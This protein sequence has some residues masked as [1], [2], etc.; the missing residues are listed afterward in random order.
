MSKIAV[1]GMVGNSA[2]L[3]VEQFHTG[4]ETITAKGVHF[5]PS[6]KGYNQAVA[7]ARS[8]AEVSFLGAVGD[9]GFRQIRDFSKQENINAVLVQKQGSTAYAAIVTD[10]CGEN[11][12]T[13]YQG[14]ALRLEDVDLF[15]GII[16]AADVLLLNNEVPEAVNV[17]AVE[18]A[19][20]AGVKVILNPAPARPL[21]RYLL[22][23]VSLFTPNQHEAEA[24]EGVE[25]LI[26]TLGNDGCLLKSEGTKIPAV[27]VTPVDTTGA[28]DTFTGVL[29]VAL[30]EGADLKTAATRATVAAG[31]SVTRPY[32]ATST[33]TKEEIDAA[34]K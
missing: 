30:A 5:E 18:I 34:M 16:R 10:S 33:P 4:G 6:G 13:V 23:N 26:V 11:R 19:K 14:A 32:A 24:L 29:A 1:I 28:G 17:R 7:A 3:S 9:E 22:E 8:G 21:C 31:I 15:D 25:N 2:F 20:A 27:P 12:V